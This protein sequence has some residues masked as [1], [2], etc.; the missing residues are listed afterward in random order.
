[1]TTIVIPARKGSKRI[2]NKNFKEFCGT[3]M[4]N[5][6]LNCVPNKL[7][8]NTIVSTDWPNIDAFGSM[9]LLHERTKHA[10]DNAGLMEVMQ[11]VIEWEGRYWGCDSDIAVCLL[12]CTPL[13]RTE[14][15]KAAIEA[16]SET[17]DWM[18]ASVVE[19]AHPI[20]RALQ[21]TNGTL[22]AECPQLLGQR[23]Q[24]C[25]VAYH[26]AGAFY[27]AS[28][29]RWMSGE[30][31]LEGARPWLLPRNEAIDIDTEEDWQVAEQLYRGQA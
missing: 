20:D 10:D 26:D 31:I 14:T 28:A 21:I 25:A 9:V 8:R 2:P 19:Y 30:P 16:H 27:I 3:P 29:K 24:D 6:A 13:L 5:R 11:D 22:G 4:I 15:L 7:R 1:M 12:P 23:T 17:P 18:M